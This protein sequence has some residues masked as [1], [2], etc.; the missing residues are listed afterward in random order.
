MKVD[1]QWLED[2]VFKR[3]LETGE[4]NLLEQS[5]RI[6]SHEK[7]E[8]LIREGQNCDG[9]YFIHSGRVGIYHNNHG[10][11]VRISEAC[12]GAQL[13]DMAS[14]GDGISS[15]TVKTIEPCV[16]YK[17][18]QQPLIHLMTYRQRLA[19]DLM[20]N[21]I[22]QLAGVIRNMNRSTAYSQQYI[23]SAANY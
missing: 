17:L 8:V 6:E 16:I 15:A 23:S 7:G 12:E 4:A 21:T 3:P 11:E 19:K 20:M 10:E 22:R 18:P 14:F 2:C 5:I 13:G 9:L 1:L